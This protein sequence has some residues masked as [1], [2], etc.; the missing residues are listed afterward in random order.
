[1]LKA[2]NYL[3]LPH[4]FE[5]SNSKFSKKEIFSKKSGFYRECIIKNLKNAANSH[6]CGGNSGLLS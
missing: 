5:K 2:I 3:I 1:M 4:I 6:Y